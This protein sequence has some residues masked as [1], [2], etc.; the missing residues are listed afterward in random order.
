[1]ADQDDVNDRIFKK[2][3]ALTDLVGE[4]RTEVA[5]IK[6][7]VALRKECQDPNLCLALKPKVDEHETM[8]NQLKGG[9]KVIAGATVASG[10]IGALTMKALSKLF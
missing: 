7:S 1:M 2:L 9:W 5:V 3:D 10:I 6:T 4:L 8:L